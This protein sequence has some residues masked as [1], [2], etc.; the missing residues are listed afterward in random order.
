M[1]AF[2][3]AAGTVDY[4]L[5]AFYGTGGTPD[6]GAM[7]SSM[8]LFKNSELQKKEAPRG[9]KL[10]A[11]ARGF[12]GTDSSSKAENKRNEYVPATNNNNNNNKRKQA[13]ELEKEKQGEDEE[14]EEEEEEEGE[15]SEEEEEEESE[16]VAWLKKLNRDFVKRSKEVQG[17][18]IRAA[19][20]QYDQD[21]QKAKD[22]AASI[23]A[24]TFEPKRSK[25]TY[26]NC[27]S[28]LLHC[29][30][31]HLFSLTLI[32]TKEWL[33]LTEGGKGGGR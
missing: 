27:I 4:G 5:D 16:K 9:A 19:S 33:S 32:G 30:K 1:L 21:N 22:D 26:I 11:K 8:E 17:A 3:G 10:V 7:D 15:E 2:L 24:A 13:G 18:F 29:N 6:I 20:F 31:S 14:D 23:I 12:K 28:F 25:C